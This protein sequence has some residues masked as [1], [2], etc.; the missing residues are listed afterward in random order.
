MRRRSLRAALAALLLLQACAVGPNYRRPATTTPGEFRGDSMVQPESLADLPWWDIFDDPV[1][2]D[3]IATSLRNNY[4]LQTAV[5]RVEQARG[6]L[7]TTRSAIFPQG[8]YQSGAAR[9]RQFS[10][11]TSNLTLNVFA[12]SLNMAWE[13]DLWGRIRRATQAS[14]AQLLATNEARRGVILSLVSEV[15]QAY[16]GLLELDAQLQIAYD[17]SKTFDA[18]RSLFQ[19]QFEGGIGTRLAVSRAEASLAQARATIPEVESNIVAVENALS[20]LLGWPPTRIPRGRPLDDQRLPPRPPP[21]LPAQLLERRPDVREAEQQLVA[22]N[23]QIGVAIA[24]FFPRI[25]LTTLYG[26]QSTELDMVLKSPGTIWQIAASVAGPI[27]QGGR[28][29][30]NYKQA[31]ANWEAVK[32]QYQQVVLVALGEVSDALVAAA[33]LQEAL[34]ER[35]N[36]VTALIEASDLATTRYTGGLGTY[37]DVLTAQQDLFPAEADVARTQRE[38]L[39]AVVQLYRA[40]GGGWAHSEEAVKLNAFPGWPR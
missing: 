28:L 13:I 18:T 24:D 16:L 15:A 38:Q 40:L 22:A 8:S 26:G 29:I 7:V 9:G 12:V 4:D 10:P 34:A 19:H 32:A 25:G 5:A 39:V 37:L 23:A 2:Q 27:F 30:G 6:I 3:L 36:A 35:A 1:L 14:Y 21:G 11:I 31:K 17:A 33:K 20:V